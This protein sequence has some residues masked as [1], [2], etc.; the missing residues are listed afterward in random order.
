[1]L[2][3][4]GQF[5]RSFFSIVSLDFDKC[6]FKDDDRQPMGPQFF[7]EGLALATDTGLV[8][9]LSYKSNKVHVWSLPSLGQQAV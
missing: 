9:Q 1:M 2:M 6:I 4:S 7:A 3:S 8:Y 5:G